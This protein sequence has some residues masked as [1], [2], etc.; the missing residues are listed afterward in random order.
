MK[1]IPHSKLHRTGTWVIKTFYGLFIRL[2]LESVIEV[3]MVSIIDFKFNIKRLQTLT[4]SDI[5]SLFTCC[6]F[7][8]AMC[9]IIVKTILLKP[10]NHFNNEMFS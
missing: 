3:G 8:V 6:A 2:I 10:G 7:F 9:Y 1:S 5:L 4:F